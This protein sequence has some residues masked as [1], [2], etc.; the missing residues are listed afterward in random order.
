MQ[1][2]S[3]QDAMMVYGEAG[4]WP[5]H[6]GSLAL[7]DVSTSP[8]GL[9]LE[10]VREVYRRRLP[11][12]PVFRHHLVRAAGGLD[13]PVWVEDPDVDVD[14]RIR[15]LRLPAPG[16]ERQLAD[17]VGE[18]CG[19]ALD[20]TKSV[21]DIWVIDGLEGDRVAILTR[22]HH[23]A[24][25][26]IRGMQIQATLYDT[27]PTAPIARSGT[28]AGAGSRN[29]GAVQLLGGAA[30]RLA[31]T[32]VRMVRTAGHVMRAA[33]RLAGVLRKNE[34]A[35]LAMPFTAP[36]TSFNA[37]V[38]A[39]RAVAFCS[40][41]LASI[42]G[43]ARQQKVTVNDVVLALAGGALRR[44]LQDRGELPPRSLTAAIPMGLTDVPRSRAVAGNK[45]EVMVTSLAT[46][47]ADPVERLHKVASSTRAG[48]AVQ[49]AIGPEL[50]TEAIDLPP[51][52]MALAARGY[53][54][55]RLVGVHP[56]VVNVV[57]SNVPGAPLP[58][59]FA[60]ARLLANYPIGPIAD[61][62]GLNMTVI[63]Y[64]DSLDV[65]LAV[66]PDL[67]EDP[68]EI[69]GALRAE[70]DELARLCARPLCRG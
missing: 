5:L 9:D 32:P 16:T 2:L 27:R 25:D 24:V 47:A 68:W 37:A 64:L 17:L 30:V 22:L 40:L 36:R 38:S 49:R 43:L 21:W 56:P 44:Y 46:D 60:G 70:S 69:V 10:R 26:G 1:R 55:L 12:L 33:G 54:G 58:L 66:C 48:K 59:Y 4:G 63:S 19:P 53:A 45:L 65:G 35:G 34:H 61:G 20:I 3:V 41:P 7:Y 6:M 14:A 50:W 18:L 15:G 67:V 11:L 62:L 28:T 23:A 52:V 31:G 42:K 13:R 29:P 57:V 39:R 8:L 51:V